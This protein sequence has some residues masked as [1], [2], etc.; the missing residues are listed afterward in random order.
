MDN[1]KKSLYFENPYDVET[2]FESL[3]IASQ[4]NKHLIF[5]DRLI[6]T[7]RIDSDADLTILNYRL[8]MDLKLLNLE[9]INE[10]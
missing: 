9:T 4:E 7:L 6:Q 8:L 2:I 3:K 10:K 1:K 5:M